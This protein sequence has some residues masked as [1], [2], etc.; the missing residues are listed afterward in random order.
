M[1]TQISTVNETLYDKIKIILS[2]KMYLGIIVAV[3]VFG[4]YYMHK[5]KLLFFKTTENNESGDSSKP[6]NVVPDSNKPMV[7]DLD[8]EY[9]ILD[10]NEHLAKINLKEMMTLHKH[11]IEQQQVMQEEIMQ[12]QHIINSQN[13][14]QV[15]K[16][17]VVKQQ[18]KHPK[19]AV[20]YESESEDLNEYS[21]TQLNNSEIN[22]LK[23]QLAELEKQNKEL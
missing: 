5:N 15:K 13:K 18:V 1:E 4:L 20:K 19:K 9:H 8:K 16:P 10:D 17:Q 23:E 12:Y 2:N 21:D 7:L 14:P 11:L 3:I 22:R 6:P